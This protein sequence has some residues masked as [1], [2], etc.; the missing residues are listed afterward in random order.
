MKQFLVIGGANFLLALL[1][2]AL[3]VAST[4]WGGF[5]MFVLPFFLLAVLPTR[6]FGSR[7]QGR[8]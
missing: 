5:V 3:G 2:M 7:A 8:S 6:M 1:L 4:F